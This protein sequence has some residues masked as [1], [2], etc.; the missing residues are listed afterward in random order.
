MISSGP[1]HERTKLKIMV[2][3][4]L[5]MALTGQ[6]MSFHQGF[7]ADFMFGVGSKSVCSHTP[8][9]DRD[10]IDLDIGRKA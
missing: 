1:T 3:G 2:I 8:D 10:Q 7:I 4:W 5:F 6:D 9:T